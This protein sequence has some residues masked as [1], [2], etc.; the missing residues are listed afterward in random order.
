MIFSQTSPYKFNQQR[1]GEFVGSMW[2]QRD[3]FSSL[4]H[5]PSISAYLYT[6]SPC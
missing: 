5:Q 1:C 4:H 3:T 2:P 6:R